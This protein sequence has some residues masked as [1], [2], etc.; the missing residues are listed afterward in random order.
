MEPETP[1]I[2]LKAIRSEAGLS[3]AQAAE[4]T[5]VSKAM[6]GQIERG[7]SSPTLITLW[8]LAKGFHLPLT[9]FLDSTAS[10]PPAPV[11]FPESI[12][13]RT[14]FPYDPALGSESF[15]ITLNPGQTHVSHPHDAG[16]VEDIFVTEGTLE[17]QT[18]GPWTRIPAGE[19]IRFKADQP[20]SYRNLT[21]APT[22]FHNTMHYPRSLG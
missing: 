6:L 18:D 21:D 20:H 19:A 13:F 1:K 7:E 5:G 4:R 10:K 15:L 9:A 22:R 12:G 16:V 2:N 8:K 11:S 3:L 17:I 14:L